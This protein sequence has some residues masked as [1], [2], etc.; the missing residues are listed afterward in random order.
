MAVFGHK[1]APYCLTLLRGCEACKI[2][3]VTYGRTLAALASGLEDVTATQGRPKTPITCVPLWGEPLSPWEEPRSQVFRDPA[4]LSSS[5]L[6]ADMHR[7]LNGVAVKGSGRTRAQLP[8]HLSFVPAFQP[9]PA[10]FS[11]DDFRAVLKFA[12]LVSVYGQIFS[13]RAVFW[14]WGCCVTWFRIS[15]TDAFTWFR[16]SETDAFTWVRIP[17]T[18]KNTWVR[19]SDRHMQNAV[20][21]VKHWFLLHFQENMR[22]G[23]YRRK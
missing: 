13:I 11:D 6:A 22:I 10:R 20:N 21:T 7:I 17:E 3:G 19:I 8:L 16:I 9:D 15:E 18:D 12:S 14:A 1:A 5:G 2:L 4:K 23:I